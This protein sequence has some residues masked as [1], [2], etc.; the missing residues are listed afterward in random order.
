M[1]ETTERTKCRYCEKPLATQE[2]HDAIAE[3]EGQDLCWRAFAGWSSCIDAEDA[4]D[5]ARE[6]IAKLEAKLESVNL[7]A[8]KHEGMRVSASGLLGRIAEGRKVE[9]GHRYMIGEML[10]H[11][12]M[13][14]D[15]YYSGDV[16]MVDRF[17]QLY[18]L[19]EKRDAALERIG[20]R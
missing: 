2:D 4:L 11:L 13:V 20:T 12:R 14:A 3:G 7:L 10:K 5:N 17:L 1:S 9:R 18:S 6:R 16:A 15:S 8:P 19:D